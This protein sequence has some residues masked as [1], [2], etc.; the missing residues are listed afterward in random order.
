MEEENHSV[1][2]LLLAGQKFDCVIDFKIRAV[3]SEKI[4]LDDVDVVELTQWCVIR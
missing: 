3:S 2:T 4:R 1:D